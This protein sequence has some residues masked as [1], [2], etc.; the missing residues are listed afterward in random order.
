MAADG[1][2]R[3]PA[4]HLHAGG[5][6]ALR[7]PPVGRRGLG[8]APPRPDR[9]RPRSCSRA[10]PAWLALDVQQDAV[11]LTGGAPTVGAP[12]RSPRCCCAVGLEPRDATSAASRGPAAR[13]AAST[14]LP[15]RAEAVARCAPDPGRAAR[16]RRPDGRRGRAVVGRRRPRTRR[17]FAVRRRRRRGPR[18]RVGGARPRRL[19]RRHGTAGRRRSVRRECRASRWDGPPLLPGAVTAT[20]GQAVE[21]HRAGISRPRRHRPHPPPLARDQ[22]QHR[23]RAR[24][25]LAAPPARAL[26]PLG[27]QQRDDLVPA[28]RPGLDLL[29]LRGPHDDH[30]ALLRRLAAHRTSTTAPGRG[31][32]RLLALARRRRSRAAVGR[33]VPQ[34]PDAGGRRTHTAPER[35]VASATSAGEGGMPTQAG[36][37][38]ECAAPSR[39]RAGRRGRRPGRRG[40]RPAARPGRRRRGRPLVAETAA[41]V[42]AQSPAPDPC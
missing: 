30:P 32:Q 37:V 40:G 14:Y 24:P 42:Q 10:A 12:S 9:R 39:S 35:R 17:V 25:A 15:V 6:A 8:A 28:R 26:Q 16:A 41:A 4:A 18:H 20:A 23:R 7:R 2:R 19:P 1:R 38:R 13:A 33:H 5:R 36:T 3:L 27:R 29:D 22:A 34:V 21:R 11:V 31:R